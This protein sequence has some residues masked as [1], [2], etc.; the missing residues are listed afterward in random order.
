[1]SLQFKTNKDNIMQTASTTFMNRHP[2]IFNFL[3]EKYGK[4]N[5]RIISFGCSTGE[6]CFSLRKYPPNADI[7][8]I[9]INPNSI[10][11]AL[12]NPLKDSRMEFKNLN[13]SELIQLDK[14]DIILALSVLCKNPEAQEINDIAS[15]YPFD[16]YNSIITQL[17]KNLKQ[18]GL[19]IIRSSN[20]R[21]R[22]TSVFSNYKVI[23]Y[24]KQRASKDFPKFDSNNKRIQNFLETE[25]FFQK[26]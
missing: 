7:I 6:E 21:F 14:C 18:D 16:R 11:T 2:D 26:K 15:I 22:D 20:F 9:D 10:K 24:E 25:E 4:K 8:G 13:P 3:Q 1:M 12:K 23:L 17:D 5:V 19:M